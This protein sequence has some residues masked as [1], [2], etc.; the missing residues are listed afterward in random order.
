MYGARVLPGAGY[1]ERTAANVRDSDG[2]VWLGDHHCPGGRATLDACRWQGKPFVI[3]FE[4]VTRP[5]QVCG[6][7]EGKGV[8]VLNVAG[9]RESRVPGIGVRADRFL[10]AVLRQLGHTQAG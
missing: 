3:A 4:G 8:R 6:W 2:T 9:N 1:P 7:V 5:S 10:A